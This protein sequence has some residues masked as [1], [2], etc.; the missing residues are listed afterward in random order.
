MIAAAAVAAFALYVLHKMKNPERTTVY[1]VLGLA[2]FIIV[3]ILTHK[4][5]GG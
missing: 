1:A 3:V 5:G 4:S 2:A